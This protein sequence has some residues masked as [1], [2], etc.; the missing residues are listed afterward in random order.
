MLSVSNATAEQIERILEKHLNKVFHMTYSHDD[1]DNIGF[2]WCSSSI[3]GINHYRANS[4]GV[5][6]LQW[7]F[8]GNTPCFFSLQKGGKRYDVSYPKDD[9][10]KR[11]TELSIKAKRNFEK[12]GEI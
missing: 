10:L 12:G 9:L 4:L 5:G 7:Q 1:E 6:I 11:L 8:R 3:T 2:V